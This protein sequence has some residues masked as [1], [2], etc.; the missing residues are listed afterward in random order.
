MS[1]YDTNLDKNKA[2]YVPLT[3]LS[4][5][6]RAK[7][8]YPNYEAIVYEDRKYTW[9]EVYKRAVKFASA[10]EKIG[11]KKGDTVSFLA[12]N[13]PEIFEAHYSVPMTSAVLNTI[14]IRLDANTI[15]YILKH[16]DAKVL[17]VDRQLHQEVKKALSQLDKEIIV[18]DIHDQF[19]DQS[20]LETIGELEYE[21]FLNTGDENYKWK[22]PEDEWQAIS[23]S[24][25]SGT[26]GNPKG[27]V[28]HHRGSYLMATGS[29]VAWNMP[30]RL[31]FL[32]IVPMF[33]C[34]GWCYPWTIP[35]LN[36]R[37][38][39]LRNIDVKKIFEVIEKY[40][41]TH[42]GGAPIVLNMITGAPEE[43][44]KK[45]KQK[46]YVLTA[47]APPPSIIFQKMKKLGFEVMHVYGLTE[48][49][50]H[51]TQ[52]AWN[53]EW[54]SL[55]EDKQNEIK[56]RQG[57]RYPNTEGV[58]VMDPE[59]MTD[60]ARDGKTIG[61]IMIRGNVVMKG[62]FKDKEATDKA[63][64]GGWFHTGDLAVMYPDGYVKIQDRSKDIIISGGE[65]ISSIEIENTLAKHPSVSISAVVAKPDE[66]WGEVPC[67]FIETV[68]GKTVTEKE[69]IEFCRETLAGFKVPK[70]IEF[71]E[72]PKTSTGKI[73]KF[74]LRKKAKELA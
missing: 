73:Q 18:I 14:N 66:K 38:I 15:S 37:T 34:N 13:T 52:C 69:L 30:N 68:Q 59:T 39:C 5:L 60:V 25:T 67:A 26:T 31:N 55:T 29:A 1:H 56:A 53:E 36:G 44:H 8:V 62:Y 70:K 7:D 17:V 51:V 4:F 32:T 45:L 21:Q 16:S 2:N 28:Y 57:V 61:E 9:L 64:S 65:N 12:F 10:L 20:K 47:G 35:M 43:Y 71:C 41:V 33:H 50:G 19:A 24:Y 74:E 48:T 27:V 49:Y 72:L 22:M 63:M 40:N 46:V 58:T 23:L 6:E 54:E 3:P 11:I 42:F